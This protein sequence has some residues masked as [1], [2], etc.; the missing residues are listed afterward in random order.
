VIPARID[1]AAGAM[2]ASPYKGLVPFEDSDTDAVLF[3]G[4]ELE[5]RVIAAN[6]RAQRVT[7]LYGPSGV[8]KSSV[9]RAGVVHDL[10]LEAEQ[11]IARFGS[12]EHAVVF[13]AEW[14]GDPAAALAAAVEAEVTR[15]KGNALQPIGDAPLDEKLAE[16][17]E[18][19]GGTLYVVLDQLE[20]YFLYHG[21]GDGPFA[22]DLARTL[23]VPDLPVSFLLSVREDA[24][25][26]LDAF[27]RLIPNL[28][29]N[30]LRLEQLDFRSAVA[31]IAG[32]VDAYNRLT[33]A[34]PPF[35]V[36]D[37]CVEAVLEQVASG[38]VVLGKAGPDTIAR[39]R[40]ALQEQ[41]F[42]TPYLQLV[43][44]RLWDTERLADSRVIRQATL[45]SL[46]GADRIVR[47]HLD[48]AMSEF[49]DREQHV[50]AR[51]FH[52]LVAPSNTKIAYTAP[53]LAEYAAVP[54]ERLVSVLVRL[55]AP[56]L[57]ILRTVPGTDEEPAYEIFHDT[58]AGAVL[59][60]RTRYFEQRRRRRLQI[61]AGVLAV[62]LAGLIAAAVVIGYTRSS[63]SGGGALATSLR[64]KIVAAA[65]WGVAH[66]GNGRLRG[67]AFPSAI[68]LGYFRLAPAAWFFGLSTG[69]APDRVV[70]DARL[71]MSHEMSH[72][73][74]LAVWLRD[75]SCRRLT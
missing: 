75:P 1:P 56:K 14:R 65:R 71:D 34:R 24:L 20:E 28:F 64:A 74:T 45:V 36:E 21:S 68:T 27:K 42:E 60:W 18:R 43:L 41:R 44:R 63:P 48:K 23:A 53:D 25:A 16:W 55:A 62:V 69:V 29:G 51:A 5:R 72:G 10:R 35:A 38:R 6:L 73:R 50:A 7:I 67:D 9:L 47:T 2:P 8:G 12:A 22:R 40:K 39:R 52:Y 32:P 15:L 49:S 61:A 57:R 59:D 17:T 54:P 4:R 13:N 33:G 11:N 19:L 58:L 31:A 37:A 30:L 46:G 66:E 70:A 3:F 26:S